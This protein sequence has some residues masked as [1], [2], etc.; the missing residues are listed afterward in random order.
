LKE[1]AALSPRKTRKLWHKRQAGKCRLFEYSYLW[2][3]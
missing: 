3:V 2:V 1:I